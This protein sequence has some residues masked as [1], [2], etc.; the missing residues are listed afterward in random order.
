M[1]KVNRRLNPAFDKYNEISV[2]DSLRIDFN[3]K[4]YLCE[5]VTRHFEV[6]H[7]Y[8]QLAY[9]HLVNEYENLFYCCQ[10]C[11]KIKPK[12]TN[13][14]SDNEILNCCDIDVESYIKLKLNIQ[15]CKIEVEQ[16]KSNLVLDIKIRNTIKVL[17][18]IYNGENSKST[19]CEDL[20]DEIKSVIASF[21]K[22]LDKYEKSKLKRAIVEE[23]KEDLDNT[24]SYS[25]FK[26]WIIRDNPNLNQQ[27][28]QYIGD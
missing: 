23:I 6:D 3:K 17:N 2:S 15:E 9:S 20:R 18:R 28:K 7:F 1:V 25:T 21:R 4:C 26:R 22:K 10:K 14:S 27:F 13:I 12:K 8:P 19:S 11:N 24:S 16:V 5:E